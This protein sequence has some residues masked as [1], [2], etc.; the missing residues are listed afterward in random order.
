MSAVEVNCKSFRYCGCSKYVLKNLSF[1]AEYGEIT[2]I[3]GASGCGK[4]TL[5]SLVNGV[6]PR[7]S[8][9][10]FDGGVLID[11]ENIKNKT[12]SEI[13]V[14]VGSVLQNAESQIIH[15]IVED[16]IAFGCEN[17]GVEAAETERRISKSC[18]LVGLE[19]NMKTR[20]L[21]GGQKQRLITASTLAI[22]L[23]ILVF[24]EPLAN[25]DRRGAKELLELLRK[26]ADGG[27][28]VLIVE[29]RLDV[30]LPY[31]DSVWK[32]E[33]AAA[34]R[35]TDKGKYLKKR[36]AVISDSVEDSIIE[37]KNAL[38][39]R[40]ISKCFDKR[41]ILT[42]IST[43]IK[44]GERI[45]LL[46]ENGCGKSTLLSIIGRLT[47]A[48]GGEIIQMID[49][50]LGRRADKHWFKTVGFVYQNPNYQLFMPSV[51]EELTFCSSDAEYALR[52]ADML[53]LSDLLP[54]HPQSLSE[55][56]KR[57]VSLAAILAQRP[58]LLLLDEPTVGQDY[59]GLKQMVSVIN[60]L[61]REQRFTII[62]ITHDFRC[63]GALC[64]RAFLI[65]NGKIAEQGGKQFVND[66]FT[67][68]PRI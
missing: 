32:I 12:M 18:K 21:S 30:V 20:T 54:R 37:D 24:D 67:R 63:A 7:M 46:G 65:E 15:R 39:I 16:E 22:A 61:H 34:Y 11:G 64:D 26:L 27:K 1:R 3:S 5:I 29:H 6:I 47:R 68:N 13:S 33:N 57:R 17:L 41:E 43:K 10:E 59:E 48:D 9:G 31:A 45:L 56:Q 58:K 62:T 28:A 35:I 38:E 52:I 50:S 14:K 23:D 51:R 19:R 36:A 4:S 25:L 49:K 40:N 60:R 8:D 66:F 44:K 53:G 2:L 42:G 55:G